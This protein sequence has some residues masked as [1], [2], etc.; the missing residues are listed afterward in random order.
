[1][2][3]SPLFKTVVL[4]PIRAPIRLLTA[5]CRHILFTQPAESSLRS[6]DD[7]IVHRPE[8]LVLYTFE[9][10]RD[11]DLAAE[12]LGALVMGETKRDR[13]FE[14]HRSEEHTSELKSLMRISYAAY[15][16]HKNTLLDSYQLIQ[17]Q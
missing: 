2:S 15:S 12:L 9:L 17:P 14:Q 5:Q 6:N 7:R 3:G 10:R 4:T 16:L 1:M 8:E 13:G 11:L